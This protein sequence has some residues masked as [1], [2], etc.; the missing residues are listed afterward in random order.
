[1]S[2]TITIPGFL[3]PL[4]NAIKRDHLRDLVL[5]VIGDPGAC[6]IEV[7][8][9]VRGELRLKVEVPEGL[10]VDLKGWVESLRAIAWNLSASSTHRSVP[11]DDPERSSRHVLSSAV[12]SAGAG[13]PSHPGT[14]ADRTS[15]IDDFFAK[16]SG[17]FEDPVLA[18]PTLPSRG[19]GSSGIIAPRPLRSLEPRT[20][21]VQRI[22]QPSC[23]RPPVA[24]PDDSGGR[25]GMLDEMGSLY[26]SFSKC[27][28]D[29]RNPAFLEKALKSF[30]R[31]NLK[32]DKPGEAPKR[33]TSKEWRIF[34]HMMTGLWYKAARGVLTKK[35]EC[36]GW[37]FM[38]RQYYKIQK[39]FHETRSE[40]AKSLDSVSILIFNA[41]A[42]L[43]SPAEPQ[44][45]GSVAALH[46]LVMSSFEKKGIIPMAF[47]SDSPLEKTDRLY[48]EI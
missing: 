5:S 29:L 7:Q 44:T 1:M 23:L 39:E 37:F 42:K 25:G 20:L 18:H 45:G 15:E 11:L 4:D 17:D 38:V 28:L 47:F 24:S 16:F 22:K 35:P 19:E 9:M 46:A 48:P 10:D 12:G 14:D 13:A 32:K 43:S 33:Y 40:E 8:L 41:L 2:F 31:D 26:D 36:A 21:T 6:E 34:S 27:V 30:I 3:N